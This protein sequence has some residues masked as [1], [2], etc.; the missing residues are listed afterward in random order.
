MK[1][2][3]LIELATFAIRTAEESSSVDAL[4]FSFST[5][6]PQSLHVQCW[7]AVKQ[8][9]L[10]DHLLEDLPSELLAFFVEKCFSGPTLLSGSGCIIQSEPKAHR[11]RDHEMPLCLS[12][13]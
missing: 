13:L 7:D 1:I 8:R 3:K 5:L 9:V 4:D 12:E 10:A 2:T 11:M 6:W